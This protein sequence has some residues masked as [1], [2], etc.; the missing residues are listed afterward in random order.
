MK[1]P[2]AVQAVLLT[3][4]LEE[5]CVKYAREPLLVRAEYR[6]KH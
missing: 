4:R 5:F 6:G 1:P 3:V 2:P